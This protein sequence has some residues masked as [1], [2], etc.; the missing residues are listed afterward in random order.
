VRRKDARKAIARRARGFLTGQRGAA[1]IFEDV[2]AARTRDTRAVKRRLCKP[3]ALSG[4]LLPQRRLARAVRCPER[5]AR[6]SAVRAR[7][8]VRA[9]AALSLVVVVKPSYLGSGVRH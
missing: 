9:A 4:G 6:A 3:K 5:S 8:V 7:T 1:R 2:F